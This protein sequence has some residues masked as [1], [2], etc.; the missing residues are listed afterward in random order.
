MK[1]LENI[2]FEFKSPKF[3]WLEFKWLNIKSRKIFRSNLIP[4]NWEFHIL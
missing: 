2:P 1:I 3:K 4:K